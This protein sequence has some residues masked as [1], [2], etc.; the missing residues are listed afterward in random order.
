MNGFDFDRV[1]GLVL[2]AFNICLLAVWVLDIDVRWLL[3]VLGIG[4]LLLTFVYL[5]RTARRD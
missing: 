5:F 4:A 3:S 1:Q 2:R